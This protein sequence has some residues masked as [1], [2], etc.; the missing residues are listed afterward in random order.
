MCGIAGFAGEG[1][2]DAL[3]AMI[4][5]VRHRGPDDTGIY[6][7][8]EVGLAHARLAIL[9]LS[10]TGHQPMF[11]ADQSVG[12][13]F[14]GEIYNFKE[15]RDEFESKG[16]RF[17]GTSDTEVIIA[18]YQEY[19][20]D[21]FRRFNGMFAIALYDF[22]NR[23]LVLA[24]DRMG[25]KPLYFSIIGGTLVFGS[26]PKAL[27]PHP[28]FKRELDP[29][30]LAMYLHYEYVPTPYSIWKNTAKLEP[31]TF[32]V[33]DGAVLAHSRFWN[34][35]FLPDGPI[36]SLPEAIRALDA[37]LTES[38]A[39]RM[40]AD[41]P[42]GIFLSGG[43]DSSTVAYYAARARSAPIRTFSIGFEDKSFDESAHA[44]R[45][46]RAL[47]TEHSSQTVSGRDMR[48][49][50]P[51]IADMLDE[52]M[53][54]ASILPT[55]LLSRFTRKHVT[56]ALDGA[57]GDELFAGYGTFTADRAA[58]AVAQLPQSF[59]RALEKAAR[60]LPARH[61][62]FSLDFKVKK[63]F[64]GFELPDRRYRHQLW[65]A[66]FGPKELREILEPP[67]AEYA[68]SIHEPLEKYW[69]EVPAADDESRTLYLYERLY[70]MD[71][72]LV[73]V[74]R[75]S[76]AVALEVRAPFLDTT[77]VD[78]AN[79]LP[80]SYKYRNGTTKYI[81]K[82]L[83]KPRLP[84]G[85]AGR[86]KQG[87]A[88]PMARWFAEDLRPLCEGVLSPERIRRDGI[89]K[90]EQI[91]RLL[92]EHFDRRA[93]NA[94]KIWTLLVFHLWKDRWLFHS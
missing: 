78:F 93:N 39:R 46:A 84:K 43:L 86:K 4:V 38:V 11:S 45:V 88:P 31:G 52:P 63:F 49:I 30:A 36:P 28:L 14:N 26:E 33:W 5:A 56:V 23:R 83:M 27:L 60:A 20:T 32:A 18:A 91:T 7:K 51:K 76:M 54:D 15:L 25:K 2:R 89:F 85:I 74:D 92:R 12:V 17:R 59:R 16:R 34:P 71:E 75:A 82:Q 90:P 81:L 22:N 73:K 66:A 62:Y 8:N 87:F 44:A 94:K 53:A 67:Y 42:L 3:A 55:F 58:Q 68:G 1:D 77:V 37:L 50:I 10:P 65:L 41:V 40:V 61:V 48:D 72:V 64:D 47:G 57:G 9:D 80:Y 24:R 19:G 69:D 29:A 21:C 79:R 13:V 6:L 70:L 35:S